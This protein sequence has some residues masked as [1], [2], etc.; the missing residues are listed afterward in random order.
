MFEKRFFYG[1]KMVE[2][3]LSKFLRVA[4]DK[5]DDEIGGNMI[6]TVCMSPSVD[7]TIELDSLNIGRT[8]VVKSKSVS[9][10]GKALNIAIGLKRLGGE[11][12]VTGVMY[13]ENGFAFENALAKEGVPFSFVWNKGRARE[14]Y[15]FIDNHSLLTEV[16]D[17][18]G[19]VDEAKLHEVLDFVRAMS[20]KCDV[21][22]VAGGLPKGVPPTFYADILRA[23]YPTCKKVVDASGERLLNAL[24]VG[25]DLVKPNIDEL[26]NTLGGTITSKEDLLSACHELIARGAK[27]VLTSLGED[28]A[29]ITD[30]KKN[31]YCKTV[32]VAVNSTVGAGDAMVAAAVLKL[33][34]G[35][36]IEEMLRHGV[37]AGS[38]RVSTL[39]PVSFEKEKYSEILQHIVVKELY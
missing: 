4:Y 35:E 22:V 37:A 1:V 36:P 20:A 2:P 3:L 32:N 12:C 31:F 24:E 8:N 33:R 27:V 21:V 29:I 39:R 30:G 14:N 23:V 18:G 34:E 17:V 11:A 28:G 38:A 5:D 9:Y 25:V 13:N 6:L 26:Q 19:S 10:A 15:K 7:V 16:N